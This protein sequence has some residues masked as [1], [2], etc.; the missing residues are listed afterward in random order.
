MTAVANPSTIKV[1]KGTS[2]IAVTLSADGFTP[3]GFV[4]A[5]LDEEF[6]TVAPVTAGKA[7]LTVG[8][9]T[10]LGAKHIEVRYFAEGANARAASQTVTVTVQKS[11]PKVKVSAPTTA[12]IGK[13]RAT[14]TV[15]VT[16]PDLAVTG[17]VVIKHGWKVV[18]TKTLRGGVA[19][20]TL[21]KFKTAGNKVITVT[22]QGSST[23]NPA[24]GSDVIRAVR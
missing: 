14:V 13:D 22:Y 18:A 6:L 23:L 7:T 5:Y 12:K 4:A 3:S 16:D 21:E 2:K 19:S 10:S 24:Q 20:V 17:R 9:F 11:T 8:P 15:R 1:K